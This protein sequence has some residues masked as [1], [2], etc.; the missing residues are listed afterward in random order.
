MIRRSCA[1]DYRV[2]CKGTQIGGGRA[3]K[4]LADNGPALSPSCK[5]AMANAGN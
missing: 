3:I 5:A 4:C 1:T 2:L